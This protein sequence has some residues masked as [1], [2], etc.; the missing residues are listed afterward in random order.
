[1]HRIGELVQASPAA[2]LLWETGPATAATVLVA[3]SQP[4]AGP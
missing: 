3:W 4:R 2:D 1:M